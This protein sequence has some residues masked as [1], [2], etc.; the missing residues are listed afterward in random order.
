ML[1]LLTSMTSTDFYTSRISKYFPSCSSTDAMCWLDFLSLKILILQ[2]CLCRIRITCSRKYKILDNFLLYFVEWK[3][4]LPRL[5]DFSF[6]KNAKLGISH[7]PKFHKDPG[8]WIYLPQSLRNVKLP[9][10]DSSIPKGVKSSKEL[11]SL[12]TMHWKFLI[13][14]IQEDIKQNL[15]TFASCNWI[16]PNFVR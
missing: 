16:S 5:I 1:T 10:L 9:F 3:K 15:E 8:E 2:N 11:P 4:R 6:N 12:S 7:Y 14:L 13:I